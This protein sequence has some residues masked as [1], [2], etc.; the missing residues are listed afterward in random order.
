MLKASEARK[1]AQNYKSKAAQRMQNQVERLIE[2]CAKDGLLWVAYDYS[3]EMKD[4]GVTHKEVVEIIH[5]LQSAGYD[6]KDN[7]LIKFLIIRW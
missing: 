1:M 7:R 3:F 6:I 5:D 2:Q 4:E